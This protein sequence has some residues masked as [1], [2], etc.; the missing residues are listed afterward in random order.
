[1]VKDTVAGGRSGY[2]CDL[3]PGRSSFDRPQREELDGSVQEQVAGVAV[4]AGVEIR[5]HRFGVHLIGQQRPDQRGRIAPGEPSHIGP[6]RPWD[7]VRRD[8]PTET[9][10]IDFAD[11]ALIAWS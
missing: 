4:A 2:P 7:Q 8:E 11:D 9:G 1:M 6:G 5:P 3:T 10:S